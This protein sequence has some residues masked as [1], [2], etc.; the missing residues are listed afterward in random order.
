MSRRRDLPRGHRASVGPL[1]LASARDV[2][3]T[4]CGAPVVWAY[5]FWPPMWQHRGRPSGADPNAG[6]PCAGDHEHQYHSHDDDL[7]D[8]PAV[9]VR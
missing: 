5:W 7:F 3:C 1:T 2:S 9:L 4:T 6:D 8:M